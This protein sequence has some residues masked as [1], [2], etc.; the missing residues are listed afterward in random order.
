MP[1]AAMAFSHKS[2]YLIDLALTGQ[3][4]LADLKRYVE[5]RKEGQT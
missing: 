5:G 4:H 3:V 1:C 2:V